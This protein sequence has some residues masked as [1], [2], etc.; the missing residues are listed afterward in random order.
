MSASWKRT[1]E[2]LINYKHFWLHKHLYLN[3]VTKNTFLTFKVANRLNTK[4]HRLTSRF[5][6]TQPKD[7][8]AAQAETPVPQLLNSK[9]SNQRSPNSKND[10]RPQDAFSRPTAAPGRHRLPDTLTNSSRSTG[11]Q[12]GRRTRASSIN[13]NNTTSVRPADSPFRATT[14]ACVSEPAGPSGA[15]ETVRPLRRLFGRFRAR[16]GILSGPCGSE[17]LT[18]RPERVPAFETGRGT[19]SFFRSAEAPSADV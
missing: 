10:R 7:L 5:T 11:N 9:P 4:L 1:P 14:V 13:H 2:I 17:R 19:G 8:T 6:K 18:L 3:F 15:S 12:P 16:S